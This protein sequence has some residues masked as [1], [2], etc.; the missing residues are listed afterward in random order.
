V[1][2]H[3]F[4]ASAGPVEA[5]SRAFERADAGLEA[6]ALGDY[7]YDRAGHS[8]ANVAKLRELGVKNIG[9]APRGRTAWAVDGPAKRR[10]VAERTR[11]E[12]SIGTL[13]CARYGFNR[14]RA[15]SEAMMGH[16]GQRAALGFNLNRLVTKL[17]ERS[18]IRLATS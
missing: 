3:R 1:A 18:D 4:R 17:A 5:V 11:V 15:R 10:L 6:R 14:P 8:E 16:C 13:K 9:L 2:H 12:A 7:A